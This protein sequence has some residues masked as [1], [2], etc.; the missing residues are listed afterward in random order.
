MNPRLL[1][2]LPAI[3]L[4]AVAANP[5]V[6]ASPAAT[7]TP[8]LTP[9]PTPRP[10]EQLTLF[11]DAPDK[12]FG[13]ATADDQGAFKLDVAAPAG[14]P[15]A[16]NVCVAEANPGPRCAGFQLQAA[17]A[18]TP[19]TAATPSAVATLSPSA[20]ASPT[21]L[22][23]AP[24]DGTGQVSAISVLLRPPFVFFPI[25]LLLAALGGAGF[26]IWSG[27]RRG[28]PSPVPAARVTHR[29]AHP[30]GTDPGAPAVAVATTRTPPPPAP[31]AP[32]AP[33]PAIP[34]APRPAQPPPRPQSGDDPLDLPQPG[35]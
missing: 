1:L 29:S 27:N 13:A 34:V 7:P 14:D 25:L 21:T 6:T 8:A 4:L 23:G 24:A 5:V 9:A 32:A 31:P 22:L 20:S 30:P 17:P 3:W 26:W 15:G 33:A 18:A 28:R 10:R 12:S 2:T 11:W 19:T 16:H 35:D